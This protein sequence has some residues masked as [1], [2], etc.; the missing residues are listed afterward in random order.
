VASTHDRWVR[1][2]RSTPCPLCGKPDNCEI[3]QD[4][5]MVWCGRIADGSLRQNGGGQFLHRLADQPLRP[6]PPPVR[7]LPR[8]ERDFPALARRLAAKAAPARTTLAE[9][10]GVSAEAL[11]RLGVGWNGSSWS[12][13]E[14]DAT[15][16]V[17]GISVRYGD[18]TKKRLKGGKA[19]LTFPTD[20]DMGSGP[21]LLAE[22][23]S[24][25]AA[26][27]GLGLSVIGRPSNAGGV[28]L[29]TELLADLP[30]Q[31]EIIVL[32]ERD[33]KP[34]GR[35]PGRDGAVGTA[36]QLADGLNR[37]IAWSLP[38]DNAKD[39]RDWLRG[40]PALPSD[41]LAALFTSG[42]EPVEV[43]PPPR[44]E[45]RVRSL[46]KIP[47]A[48][49]RDEMLR[50]RLTMRQPGYYLDRSVTGA[51]KSTLDCQVVMSIL[52]REAA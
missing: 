7:R 29:L 1:V 16:N 6:L 45:G 4:G 39:A 30:V 10:L 37:S 46:P 3:S 44:L 8:V 47:L 14:R 5:V 40:M 50:R 15:G 38:P 36:Q 26:L 43:D 42:L 32:A 12:F 18:G 11:E 23:G 52:R 17:I 22:G 9:E 48:D 25:T 24:D 31:R 51:G 35:W 20:W 13:P 27:L 28:R 41:R 21:V 49:W 33:R 19:G 34:D 2:S